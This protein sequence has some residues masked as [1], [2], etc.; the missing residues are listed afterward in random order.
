VASATHRPPCAGH[1]VAEGPARV[2]GSAWSARRVRLS[3]GTLGRRA[4]VRDEAPR[5]RAQRPHPR[6]RCRQP[7][8]KAG[9]GIL[10]D[11]RSLARRQRIVIEGRLGHRHHAEIVVRVNVVRNGP[12]AGLMHCF[13]A[14]GVARMRV[15]LLVVVGVPDVAS[16]S[17]RRISGRRRWRMHMRRS[18]A[19]QRDRGRLERQGNG[20]QR[21]QHASPPAPRRT[22]PRLGWWVDGAWGKAHWTVRTGGRED[23]EPVL[24]VRTG[25]PRRLF[26][27]RWAAGSSRT[28]MTSA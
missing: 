19:V 26:G 27:G 9:D 25:V 16:R 7:R 6:V 15:R 4:H 23:G 24:A 11:E 28:A 18:Q 10:V 13:G 5:L 14:H 3:R 17:G 1:A 22:C 20:Q 8:R 21:E 2:P 12:V